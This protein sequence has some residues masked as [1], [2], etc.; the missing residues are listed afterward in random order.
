[1]LRWVYWDFNNIVIYKSLRIKWLLQKPEQKAIKISSE[2]HCSF[3]IVRYAHTCLIVDFIR[4][5]T[6]WENT[7]SI[8]NAM[9]NNSRSMLM[10]RA[11]L[12]M[13]NWTYKTKSDLM[14]Y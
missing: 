2:F 9:M 5:E 6:A 4:D 3:A 11:L 7:R 12:S 14:V 13:K 8:R 10:K 1:M